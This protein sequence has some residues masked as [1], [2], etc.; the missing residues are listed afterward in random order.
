ML[1]RGLETSPNL[2]N[3]WLTHRSAFSRSRLVWI[4]NTIGEIPAR[5]IK[6]LMLR[7][8]PEREQRRSNAEHDQ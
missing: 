7:P 4:E 1:R 6:G 8:A 3:I 5:Q 2:L